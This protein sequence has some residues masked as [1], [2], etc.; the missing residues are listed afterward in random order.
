M[1]YFMTSKMFQYAKNKIKNGGDI[2]IK[3]EKNK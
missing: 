2:L 1:Y 3:G